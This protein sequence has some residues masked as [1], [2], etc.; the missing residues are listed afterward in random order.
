M[1]NKILLPKAEDCWNTVT[2]EEHWKD[3]LDRDDRLREEGLV[4]GLAGDPNVV[5]DI[6]CGSG[7]YAHC[8][9][10]KSYYGFDTWDKTIAYA[11]EWAEREELYDAAFEVD[12]VFDKNA[13]R[14]KGDLYLTL[15]VMRHFRDP[16]KA[17]QHIWDNLPVGANWITDFLTHGGQ[18]LLIDGEFSSLISEKMM[19]EFLQD[20]PPN[21]AISWLREVGVWWLVRLTK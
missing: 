21:N 8:L 7:R 10:Y 14:L 2:P 1:T 15:N 13:Y 9:K 11:R 17:Y 12:G 6:G 20:K 5:V 18:G 3:W 16:M 19:A 4:M